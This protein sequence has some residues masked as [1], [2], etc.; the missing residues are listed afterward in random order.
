[1]KYSFLLFA[2]LLLSACDNTN[3][4]PD[5]R[6]A[7]HEESAEKGAV[8]AEAAETDPAGAAQR[9]PFSF[10]R[11]GKEMATIVV[12]DVAE[13]KE[14]VQTF[15]ARVKRA[16]GA[17][18]QIVA[19]GESVEPGRAVVVVRVA[20]INGDAMT[21][22]LEP[23]SYRWRVTD[24]GLELHA[25]GSGAEIKSNPQVYSR[26]VVWALNALLEEGLKARWL[27]PGELGTYIPES[28]EFV[29]QI[30]E[31]IVQPELEMRSLRLLS[32]RRHQLISTQRD[33]NR[34]LEREAIQWAADHRMGT[35]SPVTFGH[36]FAHW[37]AK[38]SKDH[39][40]Y[41]A[42][43]PDTHK[44]PFP[45][46]GTV[47]L[48]LSNPAVIEQIAEEYKA[49]GAPKYWNVC[50]NDGS[51]FD[52]HPETLAWDLPQGQKP[53]DIFQ[54]RG[55]LTARYVKFWNLLYERLKQENSDVELVTYCYSSY[56]AAP[57]AERPLTAKSVLQIVD[58]AD[59][60]DNWLGW[61]KGGARI[62]LRPNWWHQGAD[63]PYLAF[64]KNNAFVRFAYDNGMLGIDMDSVLGYW[65][66]QGVNYYMIARLSYDRTLSDEQ[67]LDEYTEAFGG[68]AAKVREYI[69]Y[70]AGK[71]GEY[72]YT[73]NAT[74]G[75][76]VEK[77]AFQRL[78]D[79]KKI[80]SS[81]LNG[82]KYALPYLYTD[83][84]LAPALAL[85]DEAE[86]L[87]GD[88]EGEAA[89]RVR[90]LR[91]GLDSMK[92]TREQV[93]RGQKLKFNPTR[94]RMD[95]FVAG[96][97]ELEA[98]REEWA[99]AHVIWAESARLYETRYHILL[100]ESAFGRNEINLDGF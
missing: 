51:G 100:R 57:P 75:D 68:A 53:L 83:E 59:A 86:A 55:N 19:E 72:N 88:P 42:E 50:P 46:P 2:T 58:T 60:F 25:A 92:A 85:L 71:A 81:T 14:A 18:L 93:V 77:S 52:I 80:P 31:K 97:K 64:G 22:A 35:R 76:V 48:R 6:A 67:M 54:A 47:K 45:G 30:G 38:Y 78:V 12:P 91:A 98:R 7:A 43:L 15:V 8:T 32:N 1:M 37:W 82:S 13:V 20:G 39:L 90:F 99:G 36:N 87:A 61:A 74:G 21:E 69:M 23:E 11:E 94:E 28:K 33:R 34:Q 56:R 96:R 95:E 79:A 40:D 10:V 3:Q 66:T 41:F 63:A 4:P 65:A 44:Q 17:E 84:V 9:E 70:W 27:W 16:T 73:L 49:A 5:S 24:G 62:F 29:V 89:Q 26:P